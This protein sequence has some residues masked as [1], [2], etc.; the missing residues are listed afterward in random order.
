M[1]TCQAGP[2]LFCFY[3]M[4]YDFE[5]SAFINNLVFSNY[6][7]L[8]NLATFWEKVLNEQVLG[9]ETFRE[10]EILSLFILFTFVLQDCKI[11]YFS[12]HCSE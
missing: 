3:K 5:L 10:C 4:L 6:F 12:R 2:K 7:L 9:P 8:S 11:N 1:G